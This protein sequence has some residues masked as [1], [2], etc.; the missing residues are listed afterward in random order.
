MYRKGIPAIENS[1]QKLFLNAFHE[2]DFA[3]QTKFMIKNGKR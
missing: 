1:A 3:V 2:L